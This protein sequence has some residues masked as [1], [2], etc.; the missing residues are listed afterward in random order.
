M[1]RLKILTV[2][3]V[4]SII[5]LV[6]LLIGVISAGEVS[7]SKSRRTFEDI[8]ITEEKPEN[9]GTHIEINKRDQDRLNT[10]PDGKTTR[11]LKRLTKNKNI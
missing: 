11:S 2:L 9:N 6:F 1:L 4:S 7:A 8:L 3:V 5:L 10:D